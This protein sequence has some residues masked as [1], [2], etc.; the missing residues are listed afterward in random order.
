[1][2]NTMPLE[3]IHQHINFVLDYVCNLEPKFKESFVSGYT[4]DG[5]DDAIQESLNDDSIVHVWKSAYIALAAKHG[6]IEVDAS[7]FESF[8]NVTPKQDLFS[9]DDAV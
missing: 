2:R 6:V 3:V 4:E 5:T 8:F 7:G 9:D 1:M